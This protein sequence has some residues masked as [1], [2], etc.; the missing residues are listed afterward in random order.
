M[1]ALGRG[2]LLALC[3]TMVPLGAM[4]QYQGGSVGGGAPATARG[5]VNRQAPAFQGAAPRAAAPHFAGPRGFSAPRVFARPSRGFA[6]HGARPGFARPHFAAP[7]SRAVAPH[8]AVPQRGTRFGRFRTVPGGRT[9]RRFA[10]P[11]HRA[12]G[13]AARFRH[14]RTVTAPSTSP[15]AG[16]VQTRRQRILGHG[17]PVT[18]S[19]TGLPATQQA[20]QPAL[21]RGRRH[22]T[23]PLVSAQQARQGLFA[24]RVQAARAGRGAGRRGL[25]LAAR[26]AWR[27]GRLAG[28]VPWYGAVYWPYVYSDVFD[29]TFWPYAYDDTYWAYAYDDFFDGIFFPYGAPYDD[30]AYAGPYG[31]ATS[32]AAPVSGTIGKAAQQLCQDPGSGVTA[33]PFDRIRRAVEPNQ[34]QQALL[35]DLKKAAAS[36]ADQFKQACPNEVPL[37]PPGR[38]QAM[39]GRLQAALD[40]VKTVRPPLEKFYDSLSDEQKARFNGIGPRV[41]KNRSLSASADN[42]SACN[43][44]MAGLTT[45]PIQQ[46][47]DE[48]DPT[49]AQQTRLNAMSDAMGKAVQGLQAACPNYVPQTPVGRLDVMQKRLEAMIAAAG[50]VRPALDDFYASLTDEQKARFNQLGRDQARSR[51]SSV[52]RHHGPRYAARTMIRSMLRRFAGFP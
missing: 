35:D 31:R 33:W 39:T 7:R 2:V 44:D 32:R 9:V 13:G 15:R 21:A 37:T 27:R 14:P 19:A 28:Y 43:G 46:M 6:P 26:R 50:T 3:V 11:R 29:Y 34:D 10:V 18:P 52:I 36:A 47:E 49:E 12:V 24:T 51:R 38:L 41:G 22:G 45:F 17:L 5:A 48:L 8:F 25:H 1:R 20:T 42:G 40:A 30:Y 16:R 4:A 23:R